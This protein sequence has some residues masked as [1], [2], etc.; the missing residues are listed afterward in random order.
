MIITTKDLKLVR[1]EGSDPEMSEILHDPSILENLSESRSL[2]APMPVNICFRI[3]KKGKV[4]GQAC[5][6]NIKWIN[7]KA[8]LSVFI[9]RS[10][11]GRGYGTEALKAIIAYGF[12]RLNLYRLEAEV[13]ENNAASVKMIKGQGFKEEGRLREAKFVNGTYYDLLRFGMLKREFEAL[14]K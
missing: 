12:N 7:H 3:E 8:E 4:I 14:N 11:H 2:P 6:K 5:I 10:E 9:G 13:I 1:H